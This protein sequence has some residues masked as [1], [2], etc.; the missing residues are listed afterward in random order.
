MSNHTVSGQYQD[1]QLQGNVRSHQ[2]TE[3]QGNIRPHSV[4]AMPDHTVLGQFRPKGIRAMSDH[5]VLVQCQTTECQGNVKTHTVSVNT[6]SE[7]IV[8]RLSQDTQC[9]GIQINDVST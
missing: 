5:T 4:R 1:T 8:S 6:V 9:Q 7:N 3:C 2:T